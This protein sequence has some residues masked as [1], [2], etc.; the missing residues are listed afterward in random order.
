MTHT[1]KLYTPRHWPMWFIAGLL[2]LLIQL[3]YGIQL[4]IGKS[5]GLLAY[6]FSKREKNI[7]KI[8]LKLCFPDLNPVQLDLLL[9]KNF[10]SA[11]QSTLETLFAWWASPKRLEKLIHIDGL[12][13]IKQALKNNASGV[14][15]FTPHFTCVHTVGRLINLKHPFGVMYFPPKNPVFRYISERALPRCYQRAI[16]RDNPRLLIKALQKNQ[17]ILYTPDVD[18]GKSGLFAPFFD[19]L[20][21]TVTAASRFSAITGC[22][23]IPANY[24]RRQDNKGFNVEFH[25]PLKNFPSNNIYHDTVLINHILENFIK[26]HPEQYLWQYKRFKSRPVGEKKLYSL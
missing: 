25:P 14:L 2:W 10:I 24:Y 12:E 15:V 5:L 1:S 8:N 13:H 11:G 7:A 26:H 23:V 18:A 16:P 21:S 9:K 3:P 17:V 20:A 19:I 22:N 6:Y 4:K